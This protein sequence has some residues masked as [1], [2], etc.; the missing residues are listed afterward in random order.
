[1]NKT[2]RYIESLV[3]LDAKRREKIIHDVLNSC[4]VSADR[5]LVGMVMKARI[6]M[7]AQGGIHAPIGRRPDSLTSP[8]IDEWIGTI[9]VIA[10][11][12]DSAQ[13]VTK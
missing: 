9:D 6:N 1:M 11:N 3:T 8:E 10:T 5:A 2:T 13:N 4:F 7:A 12:P